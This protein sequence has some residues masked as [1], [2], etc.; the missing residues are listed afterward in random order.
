MPETELLEPGYDH[1]LMAAFEQDVVDP[2]EEITPDDADFIEAF[3]PSDADQ[4]ADEA[5]EIAGQYMYPLG[6][7]NE[8]VGVPKTEQKVSTKML[9]DDDNRAPERVGSSRGGGLI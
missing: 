4:E 3:A 1:E 8:T 9:F 7:L 6:H 2:I 5:S